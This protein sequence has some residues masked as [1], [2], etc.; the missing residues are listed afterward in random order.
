MG[1]RRKDEK[2]NKED[3][4]QTVSFLK[5]NLS[6]DVKR[7]LVAVFL[8][9]LGILILLGFF[10]FSGV[11]GTKLGM[12]AGLILGWT[13]FIF[14]LFLFIAGAILLFRKETAFYVSKLLGLGVTL[15]SVTAF[16][17]WF[18]PLGEMSE[19]ARAGSGGGYIGYALAWLSV[20]YIGNIGG[21][22][23]ILAL[24][25]AGFIVAF[26]FSLF[27][28]FAALFAEKKDAADKAI[29]FS[30]ELPAEKNNFSSKEENEEKKEP[31]KEKNENAGIEKDENIAKIEFVEGPD[32]YGGDQL[33]TGI[34]R[35]KMVMP[36]KEKKNNI[37]RK[38]A[39]IIYGAA[40][41]QLPPTELLEKSQGGAEGGDT[42]KNAE[43]IEM[44]LRHFGIE[45]GRG[46]T[47]TGPS[48]TQ[49]SFRPAEGVKVAQILSLQN[50]LSLALAKHPI[51]IEAPIPG[52]SLIGIEVPNDIPAKVRLRD[53]VE[54]EIFRGSD[55]HLTLALGEDVSGEY[56][57]ADLGKMPHLLVAGATGTGKSVCVNSIITT[58]L[59]QN[60][61]EDLKF[62]MVDPKRVELSLYSGIP[63]L[64]AP[65]IVDNGQVIN[66][67][68]WVVS[69]MER[70]YRLLQDMKSQNIDS[71]NEKRAREKT[72]RYTDPETG[73]TMEE[74]M[75]KLP[76]IVVVVDELAELMISHGKEVEG[77]IVRIAQLAR[78]VGIHLVIS[79][80]RPEVKVITGLIK[81]NI[82]ARVALKVNTQIDSRTILDMAGAEKLLGKGDMLYLSPDSP[83][84][85]RVQGIFISEM[86][87]KKVV[88]FIRDQADKI[89]EGQGEIN[90]ENGENNPI[91]PI[92]K[93]VFGGTA[94][95]DFSLP[96]GEEQEE[97]LYEAAKKEVALAGKAS[98]SFLQRR[99]RIGYSR[100]ARLLDIMEKN[101]IIGPAEGAKPR[102]VYIEKAA[103]QEK[104]DYENPA[105][106]QAKR[107][108]W[109]I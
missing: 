25:L 7:S 74:E 19:I 24:F 72:R 64:L 59:Y 109:Q 32:R 48:V 71:Y 88:K 79:T 106:D 68:R 103:G 29:E 13:K 18:F 99:F 70:R 86:E 31:V 108:K 80:Q 89:K 42:E 84:T 17:H 91:Q 94:I 76:Y 28:F 34:S 54:S 53:L 101:N 98:A 43:I 92:T 45:V 85:K 30:G 66:A 46:G 62:I 58:L 78:A 63:H 20:R 52:K 55:S 96:T 104:V 23:I 36:S 82:N 93:P 87:V 38:N 44:T 11:V 57:F 105:E 8:F 69:E 75:E 90:G 81:A 10:G 12:I 39:E 6:G 73:E 97:V 40:G 3:G 2:E 41:W 102:E 100:A 77:A 5:F 9:A 35:N 107:D 56:I 50:D 22:V 49:Y 61:P 65:V 14:P 47:Q 4:G 60:S 83:K 67:F 15:L 51:R 21:L 16:F 26:N 95:P 33:E 37:K 27:H 1:R